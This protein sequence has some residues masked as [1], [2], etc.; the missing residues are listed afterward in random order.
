MDTYEHSTDAW[1]F[2]YKSGVSNIWH[3][4]GT[5]INVKWI[6]SLIKQTL[7]D[8]FIQK[9]SSNVNNSSKGQMYTI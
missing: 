8:Q 6:I 3:E 5:N 4:Q 1:F 2:F 7:Q 9:G